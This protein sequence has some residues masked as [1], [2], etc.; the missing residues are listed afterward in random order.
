MQKAP[1]RLRARFGLASEKSGWRSSCYTR[2]NT[3]PP[4]SGAVACIE[5]HLSITSGSRR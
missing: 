3:A 1:I 5:N 4:R 2:A